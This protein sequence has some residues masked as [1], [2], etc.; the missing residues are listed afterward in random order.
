MQY[1][2]TK[3]V[4]ALNIDE[5][6]VAAFSVKCWDGRCREDLN[7]ST[8]PCHDAHIVGFLTEIEP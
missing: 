3:S 2:K 5:S 8:I 4:C 6:K 7:E 1:W